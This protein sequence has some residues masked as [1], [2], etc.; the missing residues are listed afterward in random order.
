MSR[1][2]RYVF[3]GLLIAALLLVLPL[4]AQKGAVPGQWLSYSAESGSTGYSAAD[5]I[6]RDNVKISR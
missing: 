4:V 5:L 3:P 6:N 2:L 1:T